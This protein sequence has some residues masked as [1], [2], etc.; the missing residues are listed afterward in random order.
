MLKN[1]KKS[2][3][4][5]WVELVKENQWRG[6]SLCQSGASMGYA[7]RIASIPSLAAD[8]LP[9]GAA[10]TGALISAASL[11]GSIGAPLGG[12]A[13]D[14]IGA[15]GTAIIGGIG[16]SLGLIFIPVSLLTTEFQT[17]N[18][19]VT[20][21]I[22]IPLELSIGGVILQSKALFFSLSVLLWSFGVSLQS[23]TLTVLA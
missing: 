10:G 11:S 20:N 2:G 6:S 9:D 16:S 18:F 19:L 7:V 13:A 21:S 17:I 23:P 14:N 12:F 5:V 22:G 15:K 3:L 8:T 4:I 1:Q